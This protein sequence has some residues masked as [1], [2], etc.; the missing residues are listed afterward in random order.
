M[1]SHTAISRP[2][3]LPAVALAVVQAL[4]SA[5][6]AEPS[7]RCRE[8]PDAVYRVPLGQSPRI[9]GDEPLVT[10]VVFSDFQCP[11]CSRAHEALRSVV[12]EYGEDVALVFKQLPLDFHNY[13]RGAAD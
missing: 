12:D 7:G 6:T 13:A 4:A 2:L 3:V 10:I 1:N 5:A 8:D 11:Y 9:G